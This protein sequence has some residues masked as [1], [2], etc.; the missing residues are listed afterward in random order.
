LTGFRATVGILILHNSIH[1]REIQFTKTD[2]GLSNCR[3]LGSPIDPVHAP[4]T[5]EKPSVVEV[6]DDYGF[7]SL[8]PP[9]EI[10]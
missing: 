9:I 2:V 3:G 4:D 7:H 6:R 8:R 1:R 5:L 10:V